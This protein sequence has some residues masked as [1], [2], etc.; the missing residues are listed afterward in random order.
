MVAWM[1]R[2]DFLVVLPEKSFIQSTIGDVPMRKERTRWAKSPAL[3]RDVSCGER[4][5]ERFP[6]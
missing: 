3:L 4:W 5:R 2:S 6:G 1:N